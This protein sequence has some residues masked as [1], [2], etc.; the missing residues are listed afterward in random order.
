MYL[1]MIRVAEARGGVPE[2]L[3]MLAQS[4]EARQRLIRQARSALIYPSIVLMVAG[5]VAT[6]LSIFILPL[7]ASLLRD[8]S[9]NMTLPLASRVLM[10]FSQFVQYAGLVAHAAGPDQLAVPADQVLQDA[11]RQGAAGPRR[12]DHA[13]LRPALPQAGHV[14]VRPDPVRPARRRAGLRQPRST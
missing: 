3:K 10:G 4:L 8:I 6:L 2:T 13:G 11:A 7:F 9:R 5:L 14:A 12:A 1:S